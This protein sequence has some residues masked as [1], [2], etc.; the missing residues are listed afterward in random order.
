MACHVWDVAV[1][2]MTQEQQNEGR[3]TMSN[4]PYTGPGKCCS[5]QS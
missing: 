2:D 1:A 3:L 4:H 5:I